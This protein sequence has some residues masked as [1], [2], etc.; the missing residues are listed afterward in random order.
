MGELVYL[1]IDNIGRN[2]KERG[3]EFSNRYKVSYNKEKKTINIRECL[4]KEL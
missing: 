2:I 4:N 1:Y 3:I